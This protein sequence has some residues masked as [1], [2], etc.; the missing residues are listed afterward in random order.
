MYDAI[1]I[2]NFFI[3][4]FS[5]DEEHPTN[6]KLNKL[7]YYA[8]GH[9]YARFNRPLFNENIQAWKYGPV[10]P[11]IYKEFQVYGN[12][13]IPKATRELPKFTEEDAELLLDVAREYG[14]Y[15]ASALTAK[16]HKQGTPWQQIFKPGVHNTVIS[17]DSIAEYFQDTE[18]KLQTIDDIV[19]DLYDDEGFLS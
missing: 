10:V 13:G 11:S 3:E 7:A 5:L 4:A 8:Q 12:N 14:Q 9:S 6:L 16:T 19:G 2:A 1:D 18:P 15:T 17:K